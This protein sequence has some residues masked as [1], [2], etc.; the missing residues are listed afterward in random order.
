MIIIIIS[1]VFDMQ[2]RDP[3]TKVIFICISMICLFTIPF[4]LLKFTPKLEIGW[5]NLW[6][7]VSEYYLGYVQSEMSNNPQNS[8]QFKPFQLRI[9][10]LLNSSQEKELESYR[11]Q[12]KEN[13]TRAILYYRR[14]GKPL[15]FIIDLLW[16]GIFIG[17]LPDSNFQQ[18][19]MTL[20]ILQILKCNWFGG[21]S[22]IVTPILFIFY[23]IKY[24]FPAAWLENVLTQIELEE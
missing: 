4:S 24:D 22:I 13:L 23:C 15:N 17:C 6:K 20:D 9:Y 8:S 16:G 7:G 18:L 14:E 1:L 5:D 2:K 11:K 12:A 3:L 21:M 10:R 19:L